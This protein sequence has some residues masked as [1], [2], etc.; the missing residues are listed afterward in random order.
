MSELAEVQVDNPEVTDLDKIAAAFS[1]ELASEGQ[2]QEQEEEEQIQAEDSEET[3]LE[4]EESEEEEP[5]EDDESEEPELYT[6]EHKDGTDEQVSLQ[7]LLDGH[8]RQKDYTQ[9]TMEVADE[10]RTIETE[11]AEIASERQ[12]LME[13]YERAKQ[14][15]KVDEEPEPDWAKLWNE[16]PLEASRQQFLWQQKEKVRD[17]QRAEREALQ[18][19]EQARQRKEFQNYYSEQKELL[20]QKIP[21]WSDTEVATKEMKE[22][23]QFGQ[24]LGFSEQEMSNV[25]DH[26]AVVLLRN[27]WKY[28]QLQGK[29]KKVKEDKQ[30]IIAPGN[31]PAKKQPRKSTRIAKATRKLKQDGSMESA[32]DFFKE[33]L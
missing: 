8:L 12:Q 28:Q 20:N 9:K 30:K 11:R 22:L 5:E 15:E 17:T 21:E 27:A 18:K 31:A 10:R 33:I 23:A 24:T 14:Y 19:A 25:T 13:L 16:D 3:E 4:E 29:T 7:Q 2:D 26:R 6:I 32:T 1:Q